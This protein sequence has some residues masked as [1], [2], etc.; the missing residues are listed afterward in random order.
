LTPGIKDDTLVADRA[1]TPGSE[2]GNPFYAPKGSNKSAS[3]DRLM[4]Y[5]CL[6]CDWEQHNLAESLFSAISVRVV[7][8]L[9]NVDV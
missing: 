9:H 8:A 3:A 7:D 2:L 5:L 6:V 1:G 4:R